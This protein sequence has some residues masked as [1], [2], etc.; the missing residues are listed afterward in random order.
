MAGSVPRRGQV[1][2][3]SRATRS[4]AG[5]LQAV[6]VALGIP[7]PASQCRPATYRAALRFGE[8]GPGLERRAEACPV[9]VPGRRLQ[10]FVMPFQLDCIGSVGLEICG[11]RGPFRPYLMHRVSQSVSGFVFQCGQLGDLLSRQTKDVP[12]TEQARGV[13]RHSPAGGHSLVSA[14]PRTP[15]TAMDAMWRVTRHRIRCRQAGGVWLLSRQRG[16]HEEE[17]Q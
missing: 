16:D 9:C 17:H 15:G 3:F 2:A 7:P 11:D 13:E 12:A 5:R 10:C 6:S 4:P 8:N 14:T 1:C